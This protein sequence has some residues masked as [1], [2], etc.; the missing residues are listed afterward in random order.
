MF[1]HHPQHAAVRELLAGGALGRL[2]HLRTGFSF[3]QSRPDD[4]RL[5]PAGGGACADLL[6]YVVGAAGLFLPSP[7]A[8]CTGF[9]RMRGGIDVSACGAGH[10]A[11]GE[12]FSF[13]ISFEQHYEC[14]YELVGSHGRLRLDRAY[15]TTP[16]LANELVLSTDAGT[17]LRPLP[18][19]DHFT[20]MIDDF[21]GR[22]DADP[23][24]DYAALL[25]AHR[26][27]DLVRR[28]LIP[29]EAA[30]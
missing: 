12:L 21:C 10:T 27:I 4:F 18:A 15:T 20:L 30:P 17:T 19:A 13:S 22:L 29:L 23:R 16:D 1:R 2:R 14:F 28:A 7:L 11:S 6:T 26:Q 5:D 25:Q 9:A 8:A 24:A 3:L